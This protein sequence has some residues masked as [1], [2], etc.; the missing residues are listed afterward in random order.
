[1]SKKAGGKIATAGG[2]K[3]RKTSSPGD[4]LVC[5]IS[6][7]LPVEPVM[8]ED[9]RIYERNKIE[10]FFLQYPGENEV[11]SPYTNEMMK[12]GLIPALQHKNVTNCL[13]EGKVIVGPLADTWKKKT[14]ERDQGLQ[15]KRE[16]EGG[17]VTSMCTL[18]LAYAKGSHGFKQDFPLA[19]TWMKKAHDL[20]S[21]I[22]TAFLGE[23]YLGGAA[24][25]PRCLPVT[26]SSSNN[27][28]H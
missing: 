20:G 16:A 12:K 24:S 13:I 3:Y 4:E 15:I 7:E 1:M 8:A 17:N 27:P 23:F 14:K 26:R 19:F 2:C 25:E 21:I 5:P 28:N 9:G 22:A 11:K 10:E 6:L 18:S